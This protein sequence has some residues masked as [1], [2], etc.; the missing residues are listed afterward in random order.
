[1]TEDE[2][3]EREFRQLIAERPY[4]RRMGRLLRD[5]SYHLEGYGPDVKVT[6]SAGQAVDPVALCAEIQRDPARRRHLYQTA[7]DLWR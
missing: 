5:W 1:M 7:M 6:D 3:T 2:I 4:R